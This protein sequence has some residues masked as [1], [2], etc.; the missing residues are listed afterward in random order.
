VHLPDR[1]GGS[2][3]E[4]EPWLLRPEE[5][6]ARLNVS[7]TKVYELMARGDLESVRVDGCRRVPVE[8]LRDYIARL[9]RHEHDAA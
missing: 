1:R 9:R 8:A 2:G 4:Q 5:A 6:A 3:S 7:R